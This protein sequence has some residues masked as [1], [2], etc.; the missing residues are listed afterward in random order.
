MGD[1]SF[2]GWPERVNL[3]RGKQREQHKK[4]V[5]NKVPST[6]GVP[7][8]FLI[9]HPLGKHKC[10]SPIAGTYAAN[11]YS[12]FAVSVDDFPVSDIDGIVPD[13]AIGFETS[14]HIEEKHI[15]GLQ[16]PK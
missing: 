6:R 14:R 10:V 4:R 1:L 5:P 15:S 7:S 16:V 13:H 8:F 12:R 3:D 11:G 2:F 9:H